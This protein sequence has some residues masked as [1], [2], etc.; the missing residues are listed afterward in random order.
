MDIAIK[1][2]NIIIYIL[3]GLFI[4]AF[5]LHMFLYDFI[6]RIY[7]DIGRYDGSFINDLIS[8]VYLFFLILF[9]IIIA[10]LIFDLWYKKKF[11]IKITSLFVIIMFAFISIFSSPFRYLDDVKTTTY[12]L[13]NLLTI[14]DFHSNEN[15]FEGGKEIK[16]YIY[17]PFSNKIIFID[18]FKIK[19][20]ELNK[21]SYYTSNDYYDES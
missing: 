7:I 3:G 18:G 5:F 2:K 17:I 15:D 10:D 6:Y 19:A 21:D 13:D 9:I 14:M 16:K 20:V 12:K 8:S 1:I 11:S 4:M